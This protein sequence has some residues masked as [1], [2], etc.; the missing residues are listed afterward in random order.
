MPPEVSGIRQ[1]KPALGREQRPVDEIQNLPPGRRRASYEPRGDR[2]PVVVPD[3]EDAL[4]EE[5]V[6][7]RSWHDVAMTSM[8][9]AYV[10]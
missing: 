8:R 1:R 10:A 3:A 7:V 6:V 4:V 2:D 5:L 9:K